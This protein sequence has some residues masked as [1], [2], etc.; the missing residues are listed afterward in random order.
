[1]TQ[2]PAAPV[3]EEEAVRGAHIPA[4]LL[5]LTG[6]EQLRLLATEPGLMPP[7]GHLTGMRITEV[8]QGSVTFTMPISDWLLTPQGVVLGGAVAILADGPLGSAVHTMLPP[9]S[10]YTTTELSLSMVRPVPRRGQ[11]IARGSL[12][13][14]GRRLA[15]TEVYV[16]DGNG[17]LLAHGTSRCF[18]FPPTE[19]AGPA[20]DRLSFPHEDLGDWTPP[21]RR[22]AL[23]TPLSQEIFLARSGLAIMRGIVDGSLPHPPL[24]YLLGIEAIRA[25][26]GEATFSMRTSDW[27]TSPFGLVEGG[28]IACLADAALGAAMQTTV[29]AGDA[30]APTDLRVQFLRPAPP[31]GRPLTASATVLHRGRT[32][33]VTRA[34]VTNGD[35]KLVAAASS[36]AV[37]LPGRRADLSDMPHLG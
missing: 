34:E 27:H 32:M 20:P 26:E 18:V 15:L 24:S 36:S 5:A 29:P 30:F 31:D 23:G 14:G 37:I 8:G 3:I 28:I 22:P 19:P 35:G 21:H 16:T 7:I 17:R 9:H 25:G 33:A 11:L 10:G 4:E 2:T 6:V 13:H 1:M 12:V